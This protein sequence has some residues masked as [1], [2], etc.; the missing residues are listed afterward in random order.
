MLSAF[1][2]LQTHHRNVRATLK[3]H[4]SS[5]E[6]H[7]RNMTRAIK[8][9]HRI[10]MKVNHGDITFSTR[11]SGSKHFICEVSQDSRKTS[12]LDSL[13]GSSV[14]IGTIQRRLAWP[15]RK[16]DTHKSR[17]VNNL[18]VSLS[19]IEWKSPEDPLQM[20]QARRGHGQ[21]QLGH[22]RATSSSGT[23]KIVRCET[24]SR[25]RTVYLHR[26]HVR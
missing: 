5:S 11:A 18:F 21:D 25:Q 22:T 14:E 10:T 2:F 19:L 17:S 4:Y 1:Y 8:T 13:R 7:E 26:H 24:V 15:L 3:N 12:F 9:H 20:P 23:K 16:D 6:K